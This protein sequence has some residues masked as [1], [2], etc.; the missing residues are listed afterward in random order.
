MVETTEMA[1]VYID[2]MN[3]INAHMRLHAPMELHNLMAYRLIFG[4]NEHEHGRLYAPLTSMAREARQMVFN[5]LGL[6]LDPELLSVT[7][8]PPTDHED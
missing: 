2:L 3:R 5:S 4:K 1:Q 6:E 8:V 7:P